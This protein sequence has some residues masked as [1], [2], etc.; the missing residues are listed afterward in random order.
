MTV[1]QLLIY[2]M[3]WENLT[4]FH[5][6]ADVMPWNRYQLL[7]KNLHVSDNLKP[8]DLEN[9]INNFYKTEPVLSHVR[10]NCLEI[11]PEQKHSIDEQV[12]LAKILYSRDRQYNIKNLWNGDLK[13][14]PDLENQEY[15]MIFSC[16][17]VLLVDK[18]VLVLMLIWRCLKLFL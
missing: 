9:K 8:D 4:R 16:I 14:F 2:N 5:A 13:I 10:K 7:R 17:Q 15:S 12:I 11:E 6:T 1:V 18:D 3:Y